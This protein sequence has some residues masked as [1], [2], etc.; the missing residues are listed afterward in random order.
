M[1]MISAELNGHTALNQALE[2]KAK[3]DFRRRHEESDAPIRISRTLSAQEALELNAEQ[4]PLPSFLMGREPEYVA[5]DEVVT[6]ETERLR[7]NLKAAKVLID[8]A[9]RNNLRVRDILRELLGLDAKITDE[10]V[11]DLP[12]SDADYRQLAMRYKVKPDHRSEIRARLQE[13]LERKLMAA[14]RM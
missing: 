11:F 1:A 14:S 3:P 13:E 8:A 2:L 12:L 9:L 5:L 10:A 6:P 4:P 7:C